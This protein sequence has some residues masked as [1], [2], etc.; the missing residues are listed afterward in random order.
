MEVLRKLADKPRLRRVPRDYQGTVLPAAIVALA[1]SPDGSTVYCAANNRPF[2]VEAIQVETGERRWVHTAVRGPKGMASSPDGRHLAVWGD[3]IDRHAD[4]VPL[5]TGKSGLPALDTYGTGPALLSPDGTLLVR[6]I[7][8]QGITVLDTHTGKLL[9]SLE[10][11]ARERAFDPTGR[12]LLLAGR[13]T[14]TAYDVPG[15]KE[16]KTFPVKTL[17]EVEGYRFVKGLAFSSD[18]QAL[19]VCAYVIGGPSFILRYRTEDWREG[20]AARVRTKRAHCLA[21]S[22]NGKLMAVGTYEPR[23]DHWADVELWTAEGLQFARSVRCQ[24]RPQN[25]G[26]YYIKGVDFSPDSK[27]V[28]AGTSDG[29]VYV[30]EVASG[31]QRGRLDAGRHVSSV[32]FTP[33]GRALLVGGGTFTIWR[34]DTPGEPA[35]ALDLRAG[36]SVGPPL[37]NAHGLWAPLHCGNGIAYL[38]RLVDR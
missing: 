33:D 35:L 32:K 4:L 6:T 30:W 5:T 38:V 36:V 22:P 28:A 3:S 16:R 17:Q 14:V 12:W 10:H 18:A 15:F 7:G 27:L 2:R 23:S 29:L 11:P 34:L 37:Q 20:A 8:N 13:D 19:F 25:Q 9:H 26:G 31:R 24:F 21:V 1:V